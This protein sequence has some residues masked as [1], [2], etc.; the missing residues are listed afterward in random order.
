MKALFKPALIAASFALLTACSKQEAPVQLT[1]PTRDTVCSLDG[2]TLVD[3]PGPKGQIHYSGGE[4]NWFCD[5]MELVSI[6][7][8]PE[9]QK[10]IRAAFVQ[11]MGKTSWD[12]PSNNWIDATKALYVQGSKK[13]GSMGP[14]LATFASQADADKVVAEHGGK[15][16]KF[17]ELTPDMVRL[18]GGMQHD[19]S[20]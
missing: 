6:Y 15:V 9:Q 17:S 11:D 5:T 10:K 16:L 8:K 14:T 19:H 1:E 13:H 4:T 7:L 18:D 3:Y 2:M 12:K 20:M